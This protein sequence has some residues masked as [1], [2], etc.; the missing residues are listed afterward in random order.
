[1]SSRLRDI[2]RA[3]QETNVSI[4]GVP[5][6]CRGLDN[7]DSRVSRA[8]LPVRLLLPVGSNASGRS[9]TI[10][11]AAGM[12]RQGVWTIPELALLGEVAQ[13]QG[14]EEF[15]GA[16]VDYVVAFED[17][18]VERRTQMQQSFIITNI[19]VDTGEFEWPRESTAWYFG[20]RT[21]YTVTELI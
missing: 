2:Y 7:L 20:V 1:M 16:L 8:N 11:D 10:L 21:L 14:L 12:G 13:G 6:P 19:A 3:I 4:N 15:A 17:A 18:I 9:I 5:I